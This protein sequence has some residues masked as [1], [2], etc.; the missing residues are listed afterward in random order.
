MKDVCC[1]LKNRDKNG[2]KLVNIASRRQALKVTEVYSSKDDDS[3]ANDSSDSFVLHISENRIPTTV[4][5]A[6]NFLP[7]LW[8]LLR[9]KV[10]TLS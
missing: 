1:K 6:V 9:K 8:H 4:N 7:A 10:V 2:Q 5:S 3:D